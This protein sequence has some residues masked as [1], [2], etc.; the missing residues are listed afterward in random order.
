GAA[1]ARQ[2]CPAGRVL[3]VARKTGAQ[4]GGE[5]RKLLLRHVEGLRDRLARQ[6]V[7]GPAEAARDDED[8]DAGRLS[9]D[10][11]GDRLDLVG[12]DGDQARLDSERREALREPRR[13][14]V[15]DVARDELVP[16]RE[17]ARR[18]HVYISIVRVASK[19]SRKRRS[20]V[21]SSTVP[22]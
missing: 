5:L 10:E 17:Q 19:R 8:V 9:A 3:R 22:R 16:D 20:W 7:R 13:V 6:V 1:A 21:T 18:G 4:V 2:P 12:H 14:R 11:L 15:R